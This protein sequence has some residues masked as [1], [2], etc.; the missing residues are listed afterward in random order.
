MTPRQLRLLSALQKSPQLKRKLLSATDEYAPGT[1]VRCGAYCF[2]VKEKLGSGL[3]GCVYRATEQRSGEDWALKQARAPFSFL[4][5]SL[6]LE[7]LVAQLLHERAGPL[8]AIEILARTQHHLF[9][10]LCTA[11][12]LQYI[13]FHKQLTT[14]QKNAL[15]DCLHEAATIFE[16][17]HLLLDLSPKNIC[18]EDGRWKLLDC[19]PKLHRSAFEAVLHKPDWE[20][21]QKYVAN[22]VQSHSSEPSVLRSQKGE[23]HWAP[24]HWAFA[25]DWWGWFPEDPDFDPDF[26]FIQSKADLPEDELLFLAQLHENQSEIVA[27]AHPWSAHPLIRQVAADCWQAEGFKLPPNWQKPGELALNK[28]SEPLTW[29][30]FVSQIDARGLG[31]RLKT[32][33]HSVPQMPLPAL[34]VRP[35]THWRDLLNPDNAHTASDILC[36]APL[37]DLPDHHSSLELLHFDLP[38]LPQGQHAR[39][40]L[41]GRTAYNKACLMV[42]GFRADYRACLTLAEALQARGVQRQ[43]MALHLGVY[44]PQGQLLISGGRWETPLIWNAL[45]YAL[46][47]LD[48]AQID[49]LAA[50]HGAIGAYTVAHLHPAVQKLILDSPM[51]SPVE[52]M[53]FIAKARGEDFEA[54]QQMLHQHDLACRPYTLFSPQQSALSLLSM[55]PE[56]DLFADICGPLPGQKTLVYSGRHAASLRHDSA[57]RGIPEVCLDAIESFLS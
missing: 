42:P 2:I 36:Q 48:I 1:W 27:T 35:Y 44:N 6:R 52:L 12:T 5:E 21:Y 41:I 17:H 54:L 45:E 22:K 53:Q 19:G 39:L 33:L 30:E 57:Q 38:R 37:P 10:A 56:K 18:W 28:Q 34:S 13:L 50:S 32:G 43:F 29:P 47:A 55:R 40:S 51:L 11:P 14:Q 49:L 26:F 24:K 9:K 46:T 8:Q 25:R 15:L 23:P 16:K 3:I 20:Q 31:K 4:S 7:E